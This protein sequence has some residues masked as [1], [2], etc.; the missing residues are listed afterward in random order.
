[1]ANCD[2][3]VAVN[4]CQLVSV[5]TSR[6]KEIV[7]PQFRKEDPPVN[8]ALKALSVITSHLRTRPMGC[9]PNSGGLAYDNILRSMQRCRR[10]RIWLVVPAVMVLARPVSP[11]EKGT[12]IHKGFSTGHD[13]IEMSE[14]QRHGYAAGFV[15]GILIAPLFGASE[16]RVHK[17]GMCIEGM[18]DFQISEIILQYISP[19]A[20][21]WHLELHVLSLQA[22]E[23]ACPDTLVDKSKE[24]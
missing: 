13:Y 6:A 23:N 1:V 11:Q 18:N 7:V 9:V 4:S 24:K 16:G 21:K 15:N 10:L 3:S 5:K 8:L 20:E 14:T 12:F 19:H 22:L 2:A 17:F